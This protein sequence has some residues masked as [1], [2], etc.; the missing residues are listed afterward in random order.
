MIGFFPSLRLFVHDSSSSSSLDCGKLFQRLKCSIFDSKLLNLSIVN[1]NND[2]IQV[3]NEKKC[4]NFMTFL[5]K[6]KTA[7]F[8]TWSLSFNRLNHWYLGKYS[9]FH[10]HQKPQVE[11]HQLTIL[12]YLE[13]YSPLFISFQKNF[14]ITIPFL[15]DME[16]ILIHFQTKSVYFHWE[17][18]RNV[19]D[20]SFL[21]K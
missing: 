9:Y 8:T 3:N 6:S 18:L 4:E 21:G 13:S 17:F 14:N 16:S 7:S 5:I 2:C 11:L 1:S 19:N 12:W 10:S 20:S 15:L